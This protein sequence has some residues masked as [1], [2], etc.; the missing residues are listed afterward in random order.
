MVIHNFL[1]KDRFDISK[2]LVLKV[3]INE[4]TNMFKLSD[5][6]KYKGKIYTIIENVV[7]NRYDYSAIVINHILFEITVNKLG[8]YESTYHDLEELL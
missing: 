4:D 2:I 5:N 6:V 8:L 1:T 3:V 7:V